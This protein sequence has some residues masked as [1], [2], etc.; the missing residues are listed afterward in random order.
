MGKANGD[1][2]AIER[3]SRIAIKPEGQP[4][5]VMAG[6]TGHLLLVI[7]VLN[8]AAA[9]EDIVA[10]DAGNVI[11]MRVVAIQT[12]PAGV[13]TVDAHFLNDLEPMA[14]FMTVAA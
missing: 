5:P 14:A 11:P 7:G 2:L 3:G 13:G 12:L 1:H 6:G 10:V 4:A 8:R 9:G